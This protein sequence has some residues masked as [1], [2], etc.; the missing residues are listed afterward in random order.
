MRTLKN[1]LITGGAGFIGS[2]FIR[3]L[4]TKTNFDGKIVNFDKLTYAGNLQNLEDLANDVRYVFVKGDICCVD[5]VKQAFENYNI[6][7]VVHFAAESHVDRSILGPADFINTNILGTFNLL[8][9]ARNFWKDF[10]GKL[11]HH[12]STDE[13][14]GILG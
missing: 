7:T 11:F 14:F 5:S 4:L 9:T 2:N 6:D 8:E 3:F 13:V 1:L 12:V 10:D